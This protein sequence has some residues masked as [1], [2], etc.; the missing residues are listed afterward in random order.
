MST[1]LIA[2]FLLLSVALFAAFKRIGRWPSFIAFGAVLMLLRWLGWLSAG[3][4]MGWGLPFA[5][6][7]VLFNVGPLRRVLLTG[8][9]FSFYKSS[10]P[11][12]SQT[13]QEALEAGTT[14]WD[15]QLFTGMPK[16]EELMAFPQVSM[17]DE[18]REFLEGPVE[19]FC[20]L[21][22]DYEIDNRTKELP[23]AAWDLIREHDF[24]GM[25]IPK[26]Y[27]GKGFSQY[28][29]AAAIMKIA[30]RSISAALTVMIP[31]SVGPGKL[32]LKYGTDEQKDHY[33]P[34]LAKAEEIPC[35]ALTAPEAGSDAGALPDTGVVC[36]G[37]HEGREVLGIRLNFD[38]RYITL[39][40]IATVLGLAFK[41]RDPDGLLGPREGK[42][43]NLG[44]TLALVPAGTPGVEQGNRHDPMHFA[45]PNGPLRGKDVFIPM[46][47]VIGGQEQIGNG[48]R[49]LM[50]S[51]TDGRAI[52][53]PALSTASAKMSARLSGAYAQVRRQFKMPIGA[54][55]GIEESLGRIGGHLYAMDAA[56]LLTL[57][58]LDQGHKPSV[59]SAIMKYN[60][61]ERSRQVI[62]DAVEVHGGAGVCMGPANPLGQ[63]YQFPAVGVTVEGHNILTRN[64]MT[65]GQG[66]IRCHPYLLEELQ[67]AQNEN[68]DEAFAAFDNAM[69]SHI[70]FAVSN[71]VRSVLLG[72]SGSRLATAPDERPE[73]RRYIKQLTRMSSAFAFATDVLLLTFRGEIKRRE[74]ISGRMADVISQL[75]LASA[76]IKHYKDQGHRAEDLPFLHWV[77]DNALYDMQQSMDVMLKNLPNRFI[78]AGLRLLLFPLGRRFAPAHDRL[79]NGIARALQTSGEHRD[80]LTSGMYYPVESDRYERILLLDQAM[81]ALQG[82]VPLEKKLRAGMKAGMV[83]GWTYDE[84]LEVAV[85][86]EVITPAEAEALRTA[87]A[88]RVR[89]I[90][91]DDFA[92]LA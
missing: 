34:R 90:Q 33:L 79:D 11:E 87:D 28:G 40:P 82:V 50:E 8:P 52:S 91:V 5:F 32:L 88:L 66:A 6:A 4:F 59:I 43:D 31:N 51:L 19:E 71:A 65:F 86:N 22:D 53:L 85:K 78:A 9:L 74:R 42:S 41:L 37:E 46:Q 21:L 12:I 68:A 44:I 17:S 72:L 60:M 3:A 47:W 25:V 1:S 14:W 58:A 69:T 81:A 39:G 38:K 30:T 48:W 62:N 67:A 45:F 63:Y 15:A 29:H 23:E 36:K 89:A 16:W 76:T 55:E 75:Y 70:G 64:L 84:Q 92:T 18:E 77:L 83:K 35:F 2:S 49:M 24:F 54:F 80:S 10:M 20:A 26:E 13:E 7:L 27:G 73:L 61:T 56:R 57:S